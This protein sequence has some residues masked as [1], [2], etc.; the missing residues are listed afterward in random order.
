MARIGVTTAVAAGT[1][2]LWLSVGLFTQHSWLLGI[3][4]S[5]AVGACIGWLLA[6][7]QSQPRP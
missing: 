3:G 1:A 4:L 5:A 2:A 7:N 6:G